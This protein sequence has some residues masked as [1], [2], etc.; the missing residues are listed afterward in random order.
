MF[1]LELNQCTALEMV[2]TGVYFYPS[3]GAAAVA[4]MP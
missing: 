1:I 2:S 3:N 4:C